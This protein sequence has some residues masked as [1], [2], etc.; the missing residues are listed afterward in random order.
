M[1]FIIEVFEDWCH[2]YRIVV[3]RYPRLPWH[4]GGA[5]F[6]L[7]LVAAL[8]T[9]VP[10]L[11]RQATNALAAGVANSATDSAMFFALA[12]GFAWTASHALEWLKT[13]LSA[14]VLAR[15]DAAFHLTMFARL[16][17]VDHERLSVED[18]GKLVS[19][20]TR[21]RAAFSA[22]T[23][24]VL[25]V[26]T[27][28]LFQLALASSVL[29]RLTGSAFA[30]AFAFAMLALLAVTCLLASRSKSAHQDIFRA[31][32]LLSSHLVEKL[33]FTL[34]VKLNNAYAREEAAL[35][36]R[37]GDYVRRV[38][39][40]NARLALLLAA[41]A[42]GA[43]LLLTLFTVMATQGVIR[44]TFKVG[45]FVMITGYVV[46]LTS[47]LT[48]LAA[49]LSD[50]RRNHL[51][52]R[53]G[54][55]L[56]ALPQQRDTSR[57]RLDR[58]AQVLYSLDHVEV[59]RARRVILRDVNLRI[60]QGELVALTGPS[61]AGKT[62]LINLMLGLVRPSDGTI[63]L[64]GA[65]VADLSI[66]DIARE[67]AVAPQS[68]MILT[69]TLRE[70]LIYGCDRPP[71][72][73][74]LRELVDRLDLRD[75]ATG[76]H[77][78]VLDRPLGIQGRALSGGERQRVALGRALARRPVVVVLDEPTSSLDVEREARTLAYARARVSTLIVITH[79]KALL[80]SADRIYRVE[81]GEVYDVT[82]A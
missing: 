7:V 44:S 16:I 25:W 66:N 72:D 57:A 71:S 81:G 6:F 40:G 18:P 22:I 8:S 13:M 42:L 2:G 36:H 48:A 14:A 4:F 49:S 61:G 19:I 65:N 80:E 58:G 67:V 32:D 69:G 15:C 27:P 29:W 56:M 34:E 21:S 70:N 52:L 37:L 75:L 39:R 64:Y 24:T 31:A 46:T 73:D 17:C 77:D 82:P 50:L 23:F 59:S 11:L 38:S 3:R 10:W 43:G 28:T 63:L 62:T 1:N 76:A 60:E 55:G 47:P 35:Q 78:D 53:E 68:P 12:Y 33:G 51:A 41:Q 45:D 9:L 79:R 5:T 30:L 74:D 20:I 26:V 54:F